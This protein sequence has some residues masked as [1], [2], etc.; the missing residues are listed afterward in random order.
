[1][2]KRLRVWGMSCAT[3][4]VAMVF[5]SAAHAGCGDMLGKLRPSLFV[6]SEYRSELLQL[7]SDE[8]SEHSLSIVGMW[9]VQLI[10]GGKVSDFGYS[11]FHSDGTEFLNS[12]GRAPSTQ[13]YCL[14]VWKKT[15]PFSYKL[16]H[17][18]LSFDTSGTLNA[19]VV[20]VENLVLAHDGKSFSGPF[21]TDI[22]DPSGTKLLQHI[23]GTTTGSRVTVD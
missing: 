9:S 3:I 5:A 1:M 15:G 4:A 20:I 6:P 18:A 13:N 11:V 19:S 21:T 17:F 10:V 14:G 8:H 2:I 12:G 23:D 7:V 22:F 16:K